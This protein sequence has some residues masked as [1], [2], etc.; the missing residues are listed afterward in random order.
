M[1]NLQRMTT[2]RLGEILIHSG[3]ITAEQLEEAI[4]DQQKNGQPLGELLVDR[5]YITERDIAEVVATQFSL[6]YLSPEQ[7]YTTSEM[8][9]VISPEVMRKHHIVPLDKLGKVLILVIS[10]P[11]DNAVLDEIEKATGCSLQ[12]YVATGSEVDRAIDKLVSDAQQKSKPK[13]AS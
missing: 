9:T 12:V 13:P 2:K 3:L 5:R 10:G 6:P 11:V 1:A 4:A 7:Y 8:A